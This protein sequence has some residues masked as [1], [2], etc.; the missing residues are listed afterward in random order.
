MYMDELIDEFIQ[1]EYS[2]K[3]IENDIFGV[4]IR[5][6]IHVIHGRVLATIDVANIRSIPDKYKGKGYFKSF[7]LKIESYNKP[8]YVEC[9]HNPHLLEMLNKHG[10]QTLIENNTVHAIKYPM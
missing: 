3:W 4:Y 6:G 2:C 1:S 10:Y 9:I 7:M 8:V 5:K